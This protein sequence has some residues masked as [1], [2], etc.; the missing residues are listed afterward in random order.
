M[1]N[2][3]TNRP[4]EITGESSMEALCKVFWMKG[5]MIIGFITVLAITG[6]ET[7]GDRENGSKRVFLCASQNLIGVASATYV[8][9]AACQAQT[10][11]LEQAAATDGTNKCTDFCRP[12]GCLA[13]T[14]PPT[15]L[16]NAGQCRGPDPNNNNRHYRV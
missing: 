16:G 15:L 10:A 1:E 14:I 7:N 2:W 6:C 12:T 13:S 11:T 3:R 8:S 4:I 5:M 9:L